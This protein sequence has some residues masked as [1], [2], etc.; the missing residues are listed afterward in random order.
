MFDSFKNEFTRLKED[1]AKLKPDLSKLKPDLSILNTDITELAP[2]LKALA[3]GQLFTK[4]KAGLSRTR[5]SLVGR[6]QSLLRRFGKIDESLWEE[7]EEILLEADVGVKFTQTILEDLRR[8]VK[9]RHITEA[10]QLQGLLRELLEARLRPGVAELNLGGEGLKVILMV[11]VN[12][13][14][15]TTSIAKLSYRLKGQGLKV[16]LAAADTFRA[17]A[18]EQ[19]EIWAGRLGIDCIKHREGSDP[20]AVV[21]DGISAAKARSADVLIVDTAGRL[22]TKV[23]LMEELKKIRRVI[24]REV[25]GGPRE[26]ILVLDATTG[27]NALEQARTFTQAVELTGLILAKLDGTAKGGIILGISEELGIPVKFVG[28]GEKVE[29]LEPFD[30]AVYLEALFSQGEENG[31]G[32]GAS[33]QAGQ[34]VTS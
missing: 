15:K 26:V 20:A 31:G 13:T 1:L 11:G 28:L 8:E 6:M 10:D 33:G 27:Q 12:G 19:L 14:G 9:E 18:I 34:A 22:Q 4:L 2:G 17:A 5:E 32:N 16:V 21:F 29:D 23:N 30:P 3:P 24:D 7:L 25:P